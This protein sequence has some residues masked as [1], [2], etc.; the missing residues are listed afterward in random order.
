MNFACMLPIYPMQI[1][2]LLQLSQA[3]PEKL[4]KLPLSKK[5]LLFVFSCV[6]NYD[7]HWLLVNKLITTAITV[8]WHQ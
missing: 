5:R 2:I 3:F 6:S 7:T 8:Q 4:S 1:S